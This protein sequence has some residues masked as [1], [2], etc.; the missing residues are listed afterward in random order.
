[1]IPYLYEHENP[2][3]KL[4]SNG[5]RFHGYPH[6]GRVAS[7]IVVHTAENLP[8]ITGD[9][10]G[11]ESVASYA[12]RMERPAS[13][14]RVVDSDSIVVLLPDEAQAFHC[15]GWNSR[16]LGLSIASKAGTWD[17]T[18]AKWKTRI[19]HNAADIAADWCVLHGI[20]PVHINSQALEHGGT[21][22]IGH[23]ELDPERR[24]DPGDDFPWEWFI[25]LVEERVEPV[26]DLY[27]EPVLTQPMT[28]IDTTATNGSGWWLIGDGGIANMG[29]APYY[30]HLLDPTTRSILSVELG[31]S[32]SELYYQGNPVSIVENELGGYTIWTDEGY[33]YTFWAGTI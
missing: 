1:M 4:R 16:T 30:G 22:L 26:G 6:R 3:A 2:N 17:Q 10:T 18:P 20:D 12:S 8:D 7:G 25:R 19:L 15:V 24:H 13:Y 32:D 31:I 27:P 21:G 29:A 23:G 28:F 11:A 33:S 14:H 5:K 9:D